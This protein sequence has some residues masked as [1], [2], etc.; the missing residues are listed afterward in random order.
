MKDIKKAYRFKAAE[1][2]GSPVVIELLGE[3]R[4][5][6]EKKAR[7]IIEN[8]RDVFD[9][10][11]GLQEAKAPSDTEYCVYDR[12]AMSMYGFAASAE[13]AVKL[14]QAANS[15]KAGRIF[16][17]ER[18]IGRDPADTES[19]CYLQQEKEKVYE[20][21]LYSDFLVY[22]RQKVLSAPL[23]EID[24][25]TYV[26]Q[27]DLLP[28]LKWCQRNGIDLFCSPEMYSGSYTTQYA[29]DPSTG[30]YYSKLVDVQDENT[31][32]HKYLLAQ[33]GNQ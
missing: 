16:A 12:T 24:K 28:P 29:H 32:I 17:F 20:A 9:I 25:N 22:E 8:C 3:H 13:E 5:D 7:T 2:D 14:L 30:K 4:S 19:R 11:E 31:W 26:F 10:D 15:Y 6:A 27:F 23:T 18:R 1:H 21:G 33:R